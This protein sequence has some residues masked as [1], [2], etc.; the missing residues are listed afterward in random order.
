VRADLRNFAGVDGAQRPADAGRALL[1]L[2]ANLVVPD[3]PPGA[4]PAA[5]LSLR[6]PDFGPGRLDIP[7][8]VPAG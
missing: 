8:A 1:V 5:Y 2:D 4:V 7:V 6:L 3:V